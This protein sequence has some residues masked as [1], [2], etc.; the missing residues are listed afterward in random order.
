MMI[1]TPSLMIPKK[2]SDL[3]FIGASSINT[4]ACCQDPLI[5]DFGDD[6]FNNDHDNGCGDYSDY[7]DCGD[8]DFN[9]DHDNDYLRS[10]STHC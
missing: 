3:D 6:D 8:D 4:V 5:A 9:R 2:I 7:N 10:E 1:M